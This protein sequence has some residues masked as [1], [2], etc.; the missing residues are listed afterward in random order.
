MDGSIS[1]PSVGAGASDIVHAGGSERSQRWE[2]RS[3]RRPE[4]EP[5]L[6]LAIDCAGLAD[7]RCASR[8][9]TGSCRQASGGKPAACRWRLY[10]RTLAGNFRGARSAMTR[11]ISLVVLFISIIAIAIG[12]GAA[13]TKGGT[14]S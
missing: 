7:E 8:H 5:D 10:G 12:Y 14:P 9:R 6:V 4:S 2:N 3:S 13:F 1:S 11:R